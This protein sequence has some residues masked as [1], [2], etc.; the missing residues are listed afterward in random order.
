M[1]LIGKNFETKQPDV[2]QLIGSSKS[3]EFNSTP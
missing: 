1:N 2:D 3:S